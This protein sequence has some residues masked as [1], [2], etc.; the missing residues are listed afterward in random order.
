MKKTIVALAGLAL[1]TGIYS[2]TPRVEKKD[3]LSLTVNT[4]KSRVDWVGSKAGDFHTGFFPLKSGSVSIDGGKL[5][6][7]KF[8]IDLANLKVTDAGGGDR[9]TGHLKSDAF[10]DVA[11]FGEATY[12]IT[13]VTYTG[14]TSA[15]VSGTLTIKGTSIP[16]KFPVMIRSASEKGFFGQAFFSIDRT[17][18]GIAYNGPSKDVQLAVHLFAK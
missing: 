16:V 2:F 18:L 5:K 12:E 3:A 17:L 11:K 6:G 1:L 10:F 9:L 14:E 13:G 4:E 15:D 8:V 7:G